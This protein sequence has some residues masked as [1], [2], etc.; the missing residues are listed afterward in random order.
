MIRRPQSL[1]EVANWSRDAHE[2]SLNVQDFLHEYK[3]SPSPVRFAEEPELLA[4]R[5]ELGGVADAYLA[6]VAASL[7]TDLEMPQPKWA[8]LPVRFRHEPWFASPGRSM[9][10][11]LII[12][13]PGPFR[14]RNLFVSSNALS[15]A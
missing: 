1:V 15:V 12:E 10:A 14:E 3:A 4:G 5:F 11:C 6:A 8:R 9:R 2:F 13:S 7:A